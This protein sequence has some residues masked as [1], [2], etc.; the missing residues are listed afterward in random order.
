MTSGGGRRT[1]GT[2]QADRGEADTEPFHPPVSRSGHV[3]SRGRVKSSLGRDWVHALSGRPHRAEDFQDRPGY[4]AVR[5]PGVGV[6][7]AV[8]QSGGGRHRPPRARTGRHPVR[9]RRDLRV[10]AQRAD[11][12]PG[13]R[14]EPGVGVPGDEDPAGRAGRPGG[15]AARRGQREPAR[16]Q[17]ARPL[18]GA[19]AESRDP[20]RHDH[21]RHARAAARRAGRR[22]RRQQL[23]PGAVARRR[24]GAGRP[25][26]EQP[27]PLQPGRPLARARPDPVRGIA[28]IAS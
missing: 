21:A 23:L 16:G 3:G 25:G 5:V 27:G 12:G 9:H 1:R 28:T 22:G 18:P 11:P 6:R 7:R 10:R 17:P 15:R 13:S 20:R 8:R 14:R 24:G 26:A 2:G 4:L 19:P